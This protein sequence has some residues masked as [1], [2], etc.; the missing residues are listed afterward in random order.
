MYTRNDLS[1]PAKALKMWRGYKADPDGY[2]AMLRDGTVSMVTGEVL[3]VDSPSPAIANDGLK[4]ESPIHNFNTD[5][6]SDGVKAESPV[7][8]LKAESDND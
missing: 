8:G 2:V 1:D 7:D 5:S 6:P 3:R 4:A